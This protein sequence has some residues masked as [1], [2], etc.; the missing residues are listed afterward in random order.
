[1]DALVHHQVVD[2]F[3]R[4]GHPPTVDE[5]AKALRTD[6]K[7]VAASLRRLHEGH[8][9]V[10]HPGSL[11]IWIAHPFSASPTAVWVA[12]RDRGWWAPCM[13][14]AFGIAVLA[15]PD[16]I[17][18]V[19]LGGEH[20]SVSVAMQHGKLE[21]DLMVHFAVPPRDAWANVVHY[22]ATVLPFRSQAAVAAWCERHRLPRGEIVPIGRVLELARA[23]Y[24]PYLDRDWR[25]WTIH[26]AQ[27][28]FDGVGLT[29]EFF[30]LPA[31]D[32]TF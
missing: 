20:E 2:S 9:L 17:I 14:C 15:A 7:R 21:S 22:C 19:R 3:V 5:I 31:A 32:V 27:S 1:M 29:G 13:W 4:R 24:G 12:E 10:L 11:D 8:G 30:R 28:I 6:A 16:A 25:K 26:E 18:H 23:W